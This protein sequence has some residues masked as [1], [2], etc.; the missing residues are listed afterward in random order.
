MIELG[1]H[2]QKKSLPKVRQKERNYFLQR[3]LYADSRSFLR[4][5][6]LFRQFLLFDYLSGDFFLV[7]SFA[8]ILYFCH[9]YYHLFLDILPVLIS[10]FASFSI[11]SRLSL[12]IYFLNLSFFIIIYKR[13]FSFFYSLLIYIVAQRLI[14]RINNW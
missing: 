11:F 13:L 10:Y 3:S 7:S 1:R 5:I 2:K 8:Y 4:S 12:S 6:S 14:V 9:F